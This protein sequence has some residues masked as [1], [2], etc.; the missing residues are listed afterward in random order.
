[1]QEGQI[2][3]GPGVG[4]R[5]GAHTQQTDL[6]GRQITSIMLAY[7]RDRQAGPPLYAIRSSTMNRDLECMFDV[8]FIRQQDGPAIRI[9]VDLTKPR[10]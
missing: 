1:M 10:Q 2:A 8:I 3:A 4:G 5:V 9:E 7:V 6:V